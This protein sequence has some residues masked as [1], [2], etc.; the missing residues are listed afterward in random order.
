MANTVEILIKARE[1][2]A[3]AIA[4]TSSSVD[5]LADRARE[6]RVPLLLMTGALT[7]GAIAGAKAASD[8]EEAVNKASEVFGPATD[9]VSTF[10][11]TS[12]EKFA[13]S[14]R[15]ANE[16]AGT[17]G[18]ILN[19]S[20]LATEAS[21]D[22]S[23]ELVK[24]AADLS[25]FNNIPIDQALEKLRSGLVGE[26]EPLRTVG[27]LLSQA[28]VEA[29]AVELGIVASGEAMS[30]AAKVQARYALI[31]EQ[32]LTAQGDMERTADSLANRL[33]NLEASTEDLAAEFGENLLPAITAGVGSLVELVAILNDLPEPAQ[34]AAIAIGAIGIA[35][36]ALGLALPPVITGLGLISAAVT[37]TAGLIAAPA[38]VAGVVLWQTWDEATTSL[39]EHL[40]DLNITLDEFNRLTAKTAEILPE[41][42]KSADSLR[43]I[44][45]GLPEFDVVQLEQ[46][47]SA[48]DDITDA[49]DSV[50]DSADKAAENVNGLGDTLRDIQQ[51]MLEEETTGGE[52]ARALGEA[53]IRYQQFLEEKRQA[54][55]DSVMD[56]L[57]DERQARQKAFDQAR[58]RQQAEYARQQQA[59]EDA[60]EARVAATREAQ[61]QIEQMARETAR[62][63]AAELRRIAALRAGSQFGNAQ[64]QVSSALGK[65][66]SGQG[67]AAFGGLFG[68]RLA[69]AGV[70]TAALTRRFGLEA[71]RSGGTV[72]QAVSRFIDKLE[73]NFNGVDVS[74][75]QA[76]A[77]LIAEAIDDKLGQTSATDEQLKG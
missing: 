61:Q 30:E 29:K 58:S 6:A 12:A 56:A 18:L 42:E 72:S 38:I 23:V 64:Q 53:A 10:A 62:V 68:V 37:S 33:K 31:M 25:S 77:E 22:M 4:K 21:A 24:L 75:P 36:G 51:A 17:L 2:A 44:K 52:A 59:L 11:E 1:D 71:E 8:L 3:R 67:T 7:A 57:E 19:A 60:I 41:V 63:E 35:L 47:A 27:V 76:I 45:F 49:V 50:G 74:D 13:V 69:E 48:T 54:S 70:D 9:R 15:A 34:N 28:A 39:E 40:G 16:Y 5:R 20:G 55:I 73:I 65:T 46:A 43:D 66:L 14:K 26:V 32:T